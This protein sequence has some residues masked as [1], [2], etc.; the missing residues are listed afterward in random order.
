MNM[1]NHL[2]ARVAFFSL[3]LCPVAGAQK[4]CFKAD[5]DGSQCLPP[6][7]TT[8][9]GTGY[10]VMDRLANTLTMNVSF[11]DLHG[12]NYAC[13][14]HRGAFGVGGPVIFAIAN[15]GGGVAVYN[16]AAGPEFAESLAA[17]AASAVSFWR[18]N[19]ISICWRWMKR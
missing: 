16:Y 11:N 18:C 4:L 9:S 15:N 3:A 1:P 8:A 19:S 6:V 14:I 7:T 2:L 13:H 17:L 10:F 5:L 12:A